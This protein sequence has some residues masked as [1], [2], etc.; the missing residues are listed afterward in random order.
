MIDPITNFAIASTV[1]D[2]GRTVFTFNFIKPSGDLGGYYLFISSTG[3][4]YINIK[5]RIDS[6]HSQIQEDQT[7]DIDGVTYFEYTT[8]SEYYD[9]KMFYFKIQ[10]LSAS[11]DV[12]VFSSVVL[13]YSY[14]SLPINLF[15][16]YTG[17]ETI[18]TWDELDFTDNKNSTFINYNLYR[19]LAV[20]INGTMYD[21]TTNKLLNDG[22]TIGS[23][24]W[25]LDIFKKSQWA[26]D[27]TTAGEFD[28]ANTKLINYSDS[29]VAYAVTI[30]NLKIF[31]DYKNP[32]LIGASSTGTF[33]DTSF[34]FDRYYI[35]SIR[36]VGAGPRISASTMYTCYTIDT[37]NAYPYLRSMDNSSTEILSD[38]YWKRIK[39]VLIDKIYYDKT[40]FAIP[41]AKDTIYNLKGYLGV[42]TCKLDIFINDIYNYTTSTGIYGEFEINY[43]FPKGNL[44]MVFQA[45]DRYNIKFSRKSAPYSIR[46]FNIYS[47]YAAVLGTQYKQVDQE[48]NSIITDVS[49]DTCRYSYFEDRFSPFVGLYKEGDEA[50]TKFISLASTNFKA[51]QYASYDKSIQMMLDAFSENLPELDHYEVY[52]NIELYNTQETAYTFT[53]TSTGLERGNYYYGVAACTYDG[54]ETPITA[55]RV[56]RRWWPAPYTNENV[57]MWDYVVGADFYRIYRGTSTEDLCFITSTGMNVAVDING[58]LPCSEITPVPYNFTNMLEPTNVKLYD[59]YGVNNLFLRLK[60]PSSLV[61]LLFGTENSIIA[62]F[63]LQRILYLL[64]K[65]IPPELNYTVIFSNDTKVILYPEGIEINLVEPDPVYAHYDLSYYHHPSLEVN[66]VY[67]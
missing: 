20:T 46:T 38:P 16:K 27:V 53:A 18:L 60:K 32:I 58:I 56:D 19:D 15:V 39:D 42:S 8:D 67:A 9:G 6:I 2:N 11:R 14:T 51:F 37:T 47:W 62:E 4:A 34:N 25:V 44:S 65:F 63:D 17:I 7:Y 50:E 5:T 35:Y 48:S 21:D 59:K 40:P 29:S 54:E 49:I 43:K 13:G 61:I 36:S 1:L 22:F 10:V 52:F 45:R 12:S 41:Y 28:L 31:I 33:T 3:I 24:I 64:K 26:G 23:I 66:E 57:I 55:L 30:D